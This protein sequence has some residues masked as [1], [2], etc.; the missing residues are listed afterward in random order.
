MIVPGAIVQQ[1]DA[2][3][4]GAM[5]HQH[6]PGVSVAVA[7]DGRV[8]YAHG[9]GYR[10]VPK[11]LPA[12]GHTVYNIASTTKQFV[13]AA[14]MR[15][16]QQGLLN[17]DDRLSK[18]YTGYKYADRVTLR[19]LLT[20]TSGI[21]DYLDHSGYPANATA[22]QQVA[23]IAKMPPEFFPGTRFEYSNSN[24]VILGLIVGKLTHRSLFD[25]WRQWFFRPLGM[26]DS[27]AGELPWTLP[28]GAMGYTYKNGGFVAIPQNVA[29]YGYGDG[30]VESSAY[31]LNVWDQALI[32]GRV[33]D[34]ASL[35]A[36]TTPPGGPDGE[37]VPGGYGFALQVETL[38]GHREW[39]HGGDNEGFHTGNAVFPDDR[40]SVAVVSN[41]NQFYY[42]WL[43]IKLFSLFHPPSSQQWAAF[44]A[45]APNQD[46]A[47]TA[48]ALG[49]LGR[50]EDGTIKKSGVLAPEIVSQIPGTPKQ[51]AS[52][53][54]AVGHWTHAVFRGMSYRS[55]NRIY[56]YLLIYPRSVV[57]YFF[58]L[59]PRG[60]VYAA[61]PVRAD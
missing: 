40:F 43:L 44:Y 60:N 32:A 57:A 48:R 17:V 29:Q 28:N 26:H 15:L 23:A 18:Y 24:Y 58:V 9:Y 22:E 55:G 6:L 47:V 54:G 36:M 14:I 8:V 53:A 35:R 11:R 21:P 3:V 59:T 20:H 7:I 19:Q 25:V 38:F 49:V 50:M 41:G 31:D 45:G 16:Q 30:G 2:V 13:A 4:R 37:P 51:M 61:L 56:E 52:D 46:L 33:V 1:V 10:N 5:A 39:E 27:T 34:E 42:G 12:D